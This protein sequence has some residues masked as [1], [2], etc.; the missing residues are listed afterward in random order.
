MAFIKLTE[1]VSDG[2]P[3]KIVWVN[4]AFIGSMWQRT[5]PWPDGTEREVTALGEYFVVETPEHIV[6]AINE[7]QVRKA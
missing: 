3:D 6:Q 2:R 5:L 4:T 1:V 7:A